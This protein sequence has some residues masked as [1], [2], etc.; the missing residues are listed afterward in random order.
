MLVQF[1]YQLWG[2]ADKLDSALYWA[3]LRL[4]Y[5]TFEEMIFGHVTF[6]DVSGHD[7]HRDLTPVMRRKALQCMENLNV[8]MNTQLIQEFMRIY[9]IEFCKQT[10]ED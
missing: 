4:D 5:S 3:T 1:L 8:G 7:V 9:E 6:D 10:I 2:D